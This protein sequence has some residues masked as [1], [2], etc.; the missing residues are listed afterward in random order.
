MA[1]SSTSGPG[2]SPVAAGTAVAPNTLGSFD[3]NYSINWSNLLSNDSSGAKAMASS[4][5]MTP[6]GDKKNTSTTTYSG[7]SR[8]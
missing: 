8:K 4:S 7:G 3:V 6:A 2:F 5:F 1:V